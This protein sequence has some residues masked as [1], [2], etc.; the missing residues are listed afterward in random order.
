[1]AAPLPPQAH[2][3][4][5]SYAT[6]KNAPRQIPSHQTEH[7]IPS[8][9]TNVIPSEATEGSDLVE[10]NLLFLPPAP[11]NTRSPT[12]FQSKAACSVLTVDCQL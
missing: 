12:S 6:S 7:A 9:R 3:S 11:N 1:H 5:R 8:Q 10:T 4:M 2:G